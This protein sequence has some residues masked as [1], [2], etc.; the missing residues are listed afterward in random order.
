MTSQSRRHASQRKSYP[1]HS[2][3]AAIQTICVASAFGISIAGV[4]I[5]VLPMHGQF[6]EWL[7]F[8]RLVWRLEN[9]VV[10]VCQVG[11]WRAMPYNAPIV[12]LKHFRRPPRPRPVR[13]KIQQQR[14]LSHGKVRSNQPNDRLA[15]KSVVWHS[16]ATT[17][18]MI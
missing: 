16:G 8:D 3:G 10:P 5:Q 7:L 1:P 11:V 17:A 13:G 4:G 15:V 18:L 9:N 6:G 12:A 14:T 2:L